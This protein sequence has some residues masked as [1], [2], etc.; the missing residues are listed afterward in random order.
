ME[1]IIG[2]I[3]GDNGK[4]V[5][6]L[7]EIIREVYGYKE[8]DPEQYSP[9]ALAYIGDT[10]FDLIV[11]LKAVTGHSEPMKKINKRAVSVV[12]ATTQAAML[13]REILP[14]LTEEEEKIYKRGRNAKSYT[15]AK[16]A[17]IIDYRSATG[18]EALIGWLYLSDRMDRILELVLPVIPEYETGNQNNSEKR[19]TI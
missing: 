13:K 16:N 14:K 9:L 12:N 4:D 19:E 1:E 18:F 10:V 11:R 2:R 15:S 3:I 17:N 5:R 6:S 7:P 8:H